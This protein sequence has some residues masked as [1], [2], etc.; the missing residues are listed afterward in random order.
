MNPED[1]QQPVQKIDGNSA[2][3]SV[4]SYVDSPF[5]LAAIVL[6][7]VLSFGGYLVYG[8]Q[9]V[10]VDAVKRGSELPKLDISR[11]EDTIPLLMRETGADLV[12]ILEVNQ[13]RGTRTVVRMYTKDGRIKSQE[14]A[15]AKLFSGN[16]DNDKDTIAL[17]AG[18][19]PCGPYTRAQSIV[20]LFY[21][22]E[23]VTFTCR[24][25]V[26]PERD[27]FVGQ[28]T[29]GWKEPPADLEHIRAVMAIASGDALKR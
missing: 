6:M 23:G 28:I 12:A 20:G 3:S 21:K 10:L 4:L 14:G 1:Q 29:L 27:Q 11:V 15:V 22:S 16:Q 13:I 9:D 19:T 26:P 25:S 2:L 18:E 7:G 5:K 17:I 8:H 24:T